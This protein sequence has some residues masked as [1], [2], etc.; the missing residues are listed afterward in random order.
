MKRK[1]CTLLIIFIFLLSCCVCTVTVSAKCNPILL[2]D[3]MED[4]EN[5]IATTNNAYNAAGVTNYVKPVVVDFRAAV[6]L[7]AGPANYQKEV[8][9]LLGN[10]NHAK[11]E[12]GD[13]T[14]G[15]CE[16]STTL[17]V[18]PAK[19]D[20][21]QDDYV[22]LFFK[23]NGVYRCYSLIYKI[24]DKTV[25]L[26][27]DIRMSADDF[28]YQDQVAY[29]GDNFDCTK[30]NDFKVRMVDNRIQV[31]VNGGNPVIDFYDSQPIAT[32]G[33]ALSAATFSTGELH[34]YCDSFRVRGVTQ[35]EPDTTMTNVFTSSEQIMSDSF[36][37]GT[38]AWVAVN[39]A[40]GNIAGYA[41]E[42]T[43]ENNYLKLDVKK[44]SATGQYALLAGDNKWDNYTF[45]FIAKS[46]KGAPG[47]VIR[48]IA[49]NVYY[50]VRFSTDNNGTVK[51]IKRNGNDEVTLASRENTGVDFTDWTPVRIRC[52]DDYIGI[53]SGYMSE[54]LLVYKDTGST[55][56]AGKAG[57]EVTAGAD[58][59]YSVLYDEVCVHT[60]EQNVIL[61]DT[62]PAEVKYA[63]EYSVN[64][65]FEIYVDVNG[66]DSGDGSKANP[67]N[68]IEKAKARVREM[69]D[70]SGDI[71]VNIAGG[72]YNL[73][74]SLKFDS[75]D[76]ATDGKVIYRSYDGRAIISGGTQVKNW[77]ETDEPNVWKA[78][79]DDW[80][81]L[82]FEQFYVNE[83]PKLRAGMWLL[84][85]SLE[86]YDDPSTTFSSSGVDG[87]YFDK[88]MFPKELSASPDAK[89]WAHTAWRSMALPVNRV[90]ED[91]TN[92]M[93]YIFE[94]QQPVF[95]EVYVL[96]QA[97][98]VRAPMYRMRLDGIREL[99]DEPGEWYYDKT[100]G[101]I[102]YYCEKGEDIN[103]QTCFV[104]RIDSL[105]EIEGESLENKVNNIVFENL[106]FR[107]TNWS[108]VIEPGMANYQ[109]AVNINFDPEMWE[110]YDVTKKSTYD[111]WF[112][113]MLKHGIYLDK[114]C[115]IRFERN[116]FKCFGAGAIWAENGT[117]NIVITGNVFE[118]I[119][120]N[121]V[122]VG[123]YGA[124]NYEAVMTFSPLL[125]YGG[126]YDDKPGE[127]CP[128][129][130]YIQN[131]IFNEIGTVYNTCSAVNTLFVKNT[132]ISNNEISNIGYHDM[133]AHS[134]KH[135]FLTSFDGME[136]EF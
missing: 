56:L 39:N 136:V 55:T 4:L 109:S 113:E 120:S 81:N 14:W 42:N 58:T 62:I 117:E 38:S 133:K 16:I 6:E 3:T 66:S 19:T 106:D 30:W 124:T 26:G 114:A 111:S 22:K 15:D 23:I 68:T 77:Q 122:T 36:D 108:S 27:R 5:W 20:D 96:Q 72:T 95:N 17:K 92:S 69:K 57:F 83:Q 54:E 94:M 34:V 52:R 28:Y 65:Q 50:A 91:P 84:E 110:K 97:A 1:I 90:Y 61:A 2:D 128:K 32:G 59:A 40:S 123:T 134:L 31:W 43:D 12:T 107:Y 93:R 103:S 29:L 86:F 102:Y 71:A 46:D 88:E 51:L 64:P 11:I 104:P 131:N 73:K 78:H 118:D 127:S 100:K 44:T 25:S 89:L 33:V 79:I 112:M 99:L 98:D 49:P 129:Y 130:T 21:A 121:G 7:K 116:T 13:T 9:K 60:N 105:V 37:N 53:Y 115:N 67:Y 76:N 35:E 85:Y 125:K 75:D 24:A 8:N 47:A 132:Y 126:A 48:Y 63:E 87:L 135:G 45:D 70:V 80:E 18:N 10:D 101:D 74:E 41:V 119:A 82:N